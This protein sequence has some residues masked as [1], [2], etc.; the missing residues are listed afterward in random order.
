MIKSYR[1]KRTARLARNVF[2]KAFEPFATGAR[3]RLAA[4]DAAK[5]LLD[6]LAVRGHRLEPL[7]GDRTGQYSIRI[8]DQW[9]VSF[10]WNE[11]ERCAEEV[12]IV[13]YH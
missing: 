4:L 7:K 5:S 13:D 6:L 8:N 9:R 2:V 11:T 12:E 10:V 3:K 1:D